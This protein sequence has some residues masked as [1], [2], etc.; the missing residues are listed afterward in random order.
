[1]L[2]VLL[3]TSCIMIMVPSRESIVSQA[4]ARNTQR[5]VTVAG[6][7]LNA[8]VPYVDA[9]YGNADGI[10]DPTEYA[11][12]YTDS[13]TGITIYLEHNSTVLFVGLSVHTSGWIAFGWKNSTLDFATEGINGS[14]LVFGCAPGTPHSSYQR[15]TGAQPI[16]V[17][18]KLL[19]RNGTLIQEGNAP[20]DSS[21]TA[22]SS[23]SLLQAYK[24]NIIGMRIGEVRHFIIPASK[25]YTDPTD[26]L[27]GQDLEY[28]VQVTR[29]GSTFDNP[30]HASR[31]S[32]SYHHGISTLQHL[33]YANQSRVLSANAS[34]DGVTTE[35]EYYIK[36]NRTSSAGV[37]LLNS[38]SLRFPFVLMFSN[39]ED[40]TALPTQHSDWSFPL[41]VQM[42]PNVAPT[43]VLQSPK[44]NES[45][46]WVTTIL[47]NATDN[48][49]VRRASCKIDQGNWTRLN[50]NFQTS[51]WE[52]AFE[53]TKY[54]NGTHLFRFN[55]TDP[56]NLT[57]VL[58]LN[59]TINRPYVSLLGMHL[60]VS[61]TIADLSYHTTRVVDVFTITNNGSA[62]IGAFE[63]Y[64]PVTFASHFL[65]L[66]A[67]DGSNRMLSSIQLNDSAGLMHWRIYLFEPA[68][69]QESSTVKTTMY[70]HSIDTLVSF[71]GNTY[72]ISFLKYP[73]VPYVILYATLS[74][75]LMSGDTPVS[76]S[77]EG[78]VSYLPPM[79]IEPFAFVMTSYSPLLIA[80][81]ETDIT[82]DPWG[83]LTYQETVSIDN[84]GPAT[85]TTFDITMPAYSSDIKIYDVVGLL[86]STEISAQ[87]KSW[88]STIHLTVDLK[89]DRFGDAFLPGEHYTF[90][91]SYRVLSS[92]HY[93]STPNGDVLTIPMTN[94]GDMRVTSHIINLILPLSASVRDISPGYRLLYGIFS[95]IFRYT[96]YN[97]TA[98]NV[99]ALLLSYDISVW[100]IARPL[101]FSL[102]VGLVAI[103]YVSYRKLWAAT[104]TT[105][106]T[107]KETSAATTKQAQAPPELLRKF[108]TT[109][110]KKTSLEL[111]LEKL[112][113]GRKRGKV[114][115]REFMIREGDIK[116]QTD[117]VEK[118]LIELK[119]E[120]VSYGPKYR[121]MIA[122]L[123]LQDERIAGAK[124]GLRQLLLRRK[125]QKISSGAFERTRQDYLKAVKKAVAATDRIL[126]TIQEE[127]GEV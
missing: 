93:N 81:R 30:A 60:S 99:P 67:V 80:T 53:L 78:H 2:L 84:T 57:A 26:T 107:G 89:T 17:H 110:S 56:S 37:P 92:A 109:Y 105:A 51:M 19:M 25:G 73:V 14:D 112:E 122:Q 95:T 104:A 65:S 35:V 46:T 28:I 74:F 94:L 48:T 32:Y 102:I 86:T 36:M 121:D 70:F 33:S 111:E 23:E 114:S 100:T 38:T 16:T 58:M 11:Y 44:A 123:D 68:G 88:N 24:D 76:S 45:L 59:L 13:V 50:Y 126:L 7:S 62:P 29:I 106:E 63:V 91:L 41:R 22:F 108:A 98:Y 75:A 52:S 66:T 120:V 85:E 77:P 1:M 117:T 125:K 69:F 9:H 124:A 10:I 103:A 15:V 18:Y 31:I 127:A 27:Y 118:D 43:L 6:S 115:Q 21:T 34:D 54:A 96:A 90:Q 72:Q 3:V 61:R 87:S 79:T 55:A 82:V 42:I 12:N 47:L 71:S 39:S 97:T 8:S 40:F 5:G 64:L 119:N 83:W 101:A 4:Q 20:D 113:D 49:Y 116:S